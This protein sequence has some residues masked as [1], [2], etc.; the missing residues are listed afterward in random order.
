M[1]SFASG[2]ASINSSANSAA[3]ISV[4]P[5]LLSAEEIPSEPGYTYCPA[6]QELV[7]FLAAV[8]GSSPFVLGFE[9]GHPGLDVPVFLDLFHM[10][11]GA[12]P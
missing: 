5:Y 8:W 11:D 7:K 2:Y 9:G 4:T 1:I 12:V 3:G 10:V 6:A